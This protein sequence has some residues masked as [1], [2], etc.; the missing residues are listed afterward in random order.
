MAISKERKQELV[1]QYVDMLQDARGIVIAEY[2]GMTVKQLDDLRA[3]LREKNASFIITKNTL[4]KIA[5]EQVG[6]AAPDDLLAG[7]VAL[8]VA[9][10]DLPATVKTVLEYANGNELFITKGGVIGES[11]VAGSDLEAISQ[12]PSLDVLRAQLVGMVTM[13]LTQF[14]GLLE[15]P[16]R[17]LVAVVRA[18]TDGLINVLAAYSRKDAA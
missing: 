4:L 1:T 5:L 18:G 9:Y 7:P 12:L 13:P 16:G 17:Q 6:M 14:V 8:A 10:E 3:K 11:A 2:R 15:E